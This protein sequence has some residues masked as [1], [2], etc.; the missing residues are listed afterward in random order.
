MDYKVIWMDEAIADL[1]SIVLRLAQDNPDAAV[2]W[3]EKIQ[4]KPLALPKHPRLGRRFEKLGREDVRELG[5]PPYRIIYH[6]QDATRMVW[7]LTVWHGA[8]Q[9]PDLQVP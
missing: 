4:Q 6:V 1:K 9:E 2:R 8:R 7:I 5:V 3:G